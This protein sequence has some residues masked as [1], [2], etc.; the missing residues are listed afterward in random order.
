MSLLV[1][2]KSFLFS[3]LSMFRLFLPPMTAFIGGFILSIQD[4]SS[5]ST[6]G[7]VGEKIASDL[8]VSLNKYR[9]GYL[10]YNNM[11]IRGNNDKLSQVDHL[12]LSKYGIMLIETKHYSGTVFCSEQNRYWP[13]YSEKG[14]RY[15]LYNPLHQSYGH[16]VAVRNF[17]SSVV[18]KSKL[19]K[20]VFDFV[21]FT[22]SARLKGND[23]LERVTTPD[24]LLLQILHRDT[25]VLTTK[26][27]KSLDTLF[28]EVENNRGTLEIE[29]ALSLRNDTSGNKF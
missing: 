10:L 3:S 15:E 27:I 23:L 6:L 19:M 9:H 5:A 26:M 4:V 21:C 22:G 7:K 12:L 13:V 25:E 29:H 24:S 20:S 2:R 28:T 14:T 11:F 8:L 1:L 17:I 18:S 16:K